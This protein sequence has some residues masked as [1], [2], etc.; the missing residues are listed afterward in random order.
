[1]IQLILQI[2]DNLH[3]EFKSKCALEQK[4][5]KDKLEELMK[6]YIN[7]KKEVKADESKTNKYY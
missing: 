2:E 3:A 6:E 1:M 7:R 5:M 4:A